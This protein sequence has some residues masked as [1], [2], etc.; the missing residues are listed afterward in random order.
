MRDERQIRVRTGN[1]STI[2]EFPGVDDLRA[3]T[4]HD[5]EN[6]QAAVV[7]IE[8]NAITAQVVDGT[9]GATIQRAHAFAERDELLREGANVCGCLRRNCVPLGSRCIP[10]ASLPGNGNRDTYGGRL[11]KVAN[12]GTEFDVHA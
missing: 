12:N 6:G 10:K 1:P 7:P 4:D 3:R 8:E 5:R 11:G 2:L 9:A